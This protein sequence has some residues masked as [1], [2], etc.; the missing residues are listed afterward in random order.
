MAQFLQKKKEM[1]FGARLGLE[2]PREAPC[3]RRSPAPLLPASTHR[4]PRTHTHILK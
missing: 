2:Y 1:Y 3:G 4:E